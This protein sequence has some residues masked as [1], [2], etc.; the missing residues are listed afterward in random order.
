MGLHKIDKSKLVEPKVKTTPQNVKEA[1][2][3]LYRARLNLP[4]AAKHCGMTEKEM[5]MTFLEYLKYHP[6]D[7]ESTENTP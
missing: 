4:A 3:A 1:N 7:Y 5:K 2:Q 6:I